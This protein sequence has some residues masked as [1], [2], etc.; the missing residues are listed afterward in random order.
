MRITHDLGRLEKDLGRLASKVLPKAVPPAINRVTKSTRTAA[1]RHIAQTTGVKNRDVA[2]R[3]DTKLARRNDLTAYID[4]SRSRTFNLVRFVTP[5][6][7]KEGERGSPQF[8]R[9]RARGKSRG[10]LR[11]GVK[12]KAWRTPRVYPGTFIAQGRSGNVLVFKR[13]GSRRNSKI[14][15]VHGPSVRNEFNRA[16]TR[17][18]MTTRANERFPIEM[19]RSLARAMKSA[20]L[21][22]SR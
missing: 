7:A 3:M 5:S 22:P 13:T 20:G 16:T 6:Q 9:K 10:Y 18:V 4:A 15:A 12:A 14:E 17:R 1:V 21:R 8:F 2:E 11:R 19:D